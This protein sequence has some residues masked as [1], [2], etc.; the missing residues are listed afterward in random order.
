MSPFL[1]IYSVFL[2][3]NFLQLSHWAFIPNSCVHYWVPVL[4]SLHN[5]QVNQTFGFTL[6]SLSRAHLWIVITLKFLSFSGTRKSCATSNWYFFLWVN[7]V[8]RTENGSH[9]F[10]QPEL[11]SPISKGRWHIIYWVSFKSIVGF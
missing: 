10:P 6:L 1:S 7:L 8:T 3:I 9:L 2:Q 11:D 5:C 4:G